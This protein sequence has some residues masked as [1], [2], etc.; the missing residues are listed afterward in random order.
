[1]KSTH[2]W[3][4]FEKKKLGAFTCR[5]PTRSLNFY[6]FEF[7]SLETNTLDLQPVYADPPVSVSLLKQKV[8][9][10]WRTLWWNI[11]FKASKGFM[12]II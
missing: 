9:I 3:A 8:L 2:V 4:V 6:C 11:L 1:M 10:L 5:L 7:S 12:N